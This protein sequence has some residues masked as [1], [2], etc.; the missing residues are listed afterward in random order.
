[1]KQISL[2]G[3]LR[4][5]GLAANILSI[6]Q[7]K[8]TTHDLGNGVA[9]YNITFKQETLMDTTLF[10]DFYYN[11]ARMNAILIMDS[12]GIILNV[13][14]AFTTHFG[15]SNEEIKGRNFST[16]FTKSD[17]ERN[18][19]RQEIEAV[20]ATGQSNDENYVVDKD[21]QAIWCTGESLLVSGQQGEKYI[22]KD[23]INLQAKKQLQL[24]LTA[25]EELLGKVF[26]TSRDFSMVIL[27]GSMKMVKA[28]KAFLNLFEMEESPFAGCSLSDIDHLFWSRDD[29]RKEIR[30]SIVTNQS[31]KQKE[32]IV[33]TKSGEKKT[34]RLDSKII[35]K[36]QGK[37]KRILLIIEDITPEPTGV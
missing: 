33:E 11:N 5:R 8:F 24:F 1:M 31:I 7:L 27:D 9:A 18:Q 26:E 20:L 32:F 15:Y 22:I 16:L 29:V 19:P 17:K 37:D 28:N 10:F 6:I 36:E 12:N 3:P 23:I 21:G 14:K 25:T 2:S 30:N 34:I 13:N 35:D 4:F